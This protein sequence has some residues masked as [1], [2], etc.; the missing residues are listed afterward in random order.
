M[1][2]PRFVNGPHAPVPHTII[3]KPVP[4]SAIH[5]SV[6]RSVITSPVPHTIIRK[7]QKAPVKAGEE[8]GC[9]CVVM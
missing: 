6:Q 9:G 3:R 7:P 2:P 5:P 4:S 8:S 1:P